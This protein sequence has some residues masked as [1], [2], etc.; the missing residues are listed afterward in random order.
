MTYMVDVGMLLG[1]Q[2]NSTHE[3]M[4]QVLQLE[5]AIANITS[6]Q[7]D[8]RDEEAMYHRMSIAEL[9][10]LDVHKVFGI[11]RYMCVTHCLSGEKIDEKLVLR[12]KAC[13]S[14]STDRE[15]NGWN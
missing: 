8:H 5:T 12:V 11:S 14:V 1:G 3:Q 15:N 10:V 2:E 9:Q 7:E 6:P 4:Q 13:R